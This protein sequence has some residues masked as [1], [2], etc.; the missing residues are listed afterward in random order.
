M[1]D[2]VASP[3]LLLEERVT[4]VAIESDGVAVHVSSNQVDDFSVLEV[5]E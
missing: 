4:G 5:V 2:L 1:A 3:S